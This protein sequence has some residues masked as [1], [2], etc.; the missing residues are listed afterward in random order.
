M[1]LL[2]HCPAAI[3]APFLRLMRTR[4]FAKTNWNLPGTRDCPGQQSSEQSINKL[5]PRGAYKLKRFKM[6]PI[7]WKDKVIPFPNSCP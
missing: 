7:K 2:V 3:S 6:L 4:W 5:R 1:K